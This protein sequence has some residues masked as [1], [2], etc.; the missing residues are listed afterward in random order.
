M[1]FRIPITTLRFGDLTQMEKHGSMVE[2][3]PQIWAE[4]SGLGGGFQGYLNFDEEGKVTFLVGSGYIQA[5]NIDSTKF[6]YDYMAT[7][8]RILPTPDLQD[9]ACVVLSSPRWEQE[10]NFSK[11]S[12]V[13]VI[14]HRLGSVNKMTWWNSR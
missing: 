8:K 7:R 2:S 12:K 10:R 13:K 9:N 4:Y 14:Y 5:I 11:C 1:R 3:S 6:T